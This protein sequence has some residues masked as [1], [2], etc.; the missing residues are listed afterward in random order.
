MIR[1][2]QVRGSTDTVFFAERS[3]DRSLIY[4][5]EFH[6]NSSRKLTKVLVYEL[7]SRLVAIDFASNSLT[8]KTERPSLFLLGEDQK[9]HFLEMCEDSSYKC[10]N[11]ADY[12]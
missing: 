7:N 1:E 3:L 5:L 4:K 2:Y 12:S 6:A 11:V 10:T 9:V 8:Y